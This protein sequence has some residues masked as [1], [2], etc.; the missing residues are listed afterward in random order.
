M[1]RQRNHGIRKR[2]GCPRPK[3]PK[4][5]HGWHFNFSWKGVTHRLSLDRECGRHIESKTEAQREA[6]RLRSEIRNGDFRSTTATSSESELRFG[7]VLDRYVAGHVRILTRRLRAQQEM[8]YQVEALRR[9]EIPG[10]D[11]KAIRLEDSPLSAIITPDVEALRATRRSRSGNTGSKGGEVGTNR[12]LARLRH[13]FSWAIALGYV[14]RTPFKR[15]GVSVIRLESS[16]EKPRQ[17]RLKPGEENRLLA[18]AKPHLY[19]LVVAALETGCR[20]GELLTM[21]WH[22]IRWD[23]N[24]V[25]LPDDSTKTQTARVVPMSVRLKAILEMRRTDPDGRMFP[26]DAYVFGNEIGEPIRSIKTAWR[27]SCRRAGITGLR[28][29]DLRREFAS[30]VLATT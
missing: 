9:A 11:G 25:F 3:W 30:R 19:A 12:L 13:I 24:L 23:Q 14:D 29:H 26:E 28:F 16:V 18:E 27:S 10:A 1:P 22:Q 7:Q 5:K 2:C 20:K 8:L 4:C 17:R 21:Q 6:D 15:N